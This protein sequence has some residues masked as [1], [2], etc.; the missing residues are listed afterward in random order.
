MQPHRSET[1][2]FIETGQIIPLPEAHDYLVKVKTREEEQNKERQQI[3]GKYYRGGNIFADRVDRTEEGNMEKL[4]RLYEWAIGLEREMMAIL[5]SYIKNDICNLLVGLPTGN[6]PNLVSVIMSQSVLRFH[7]RHLEQ[8]SPQSAQRLQE[9][10]GQQILGRKSPFNIKLENI[11]DEYLPTLTEAYREANDLL[12]E[13][14]TA[15]E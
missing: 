5:Y 3:M 12:A 7:P 11:M 4:G 13:N 14:S 10:L 15:S 9:L 1:E 2:L 8:Y 6:N